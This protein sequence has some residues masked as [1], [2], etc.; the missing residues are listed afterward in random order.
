MQAAEFHR[1]LQARWSEV[2][3]KVGRL[4][5][6]TWEFGANPHFRTRRGF[7]VT[8]TFPDGRCAFRYAKKI[9]KQPRSRIEGIIRHEFGHVVDALVP[10]SKLPPGLPKTSERRADAIAEWIWGEPIYY[11][12]KAWV[13]NLTSGERPRPQALGNPLDFPSTGITTFSERRL[14]EKLAPWDDAYRLPGETANYVA[15]TELWLN[16][17]LPP[18]YSFDAPREWRCGF[19]GCTFAIHLNGEHYCRAKVTTDATEAATA[20]AVNAYRKAQPIEDAHR[21]LPWIFG[22][23]AVPRAGVYMIFREELDELDL[24]SPWVLD[25]V[26][27]YAN[28]IRFGRGVEP[29]PQDRTRVA[30]LLER[31]NRL[32]DQGLFYSVDVREDNVRVRPSTGELVI[33]D[34]GRSYGP[35]AT[36]PTAENP[37][38]KSWKRG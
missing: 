20:A 28:E 33:S 9:L 31:L 19:F 27:L 15:A 2:Q 18:E 13:Q 29:D 1:L 24:A 34:L 36:I 14:G 11:D 22:V 37:K 10:A 30:Q 21:A 4:P 6:L 32:K 5:P 3:R 26:G 38:W 16:E 7:G 35:R 17:R 8:F 12:R 23:W 25:E